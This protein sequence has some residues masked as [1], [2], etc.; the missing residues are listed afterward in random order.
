MRRVSMGEVLPPD[1]IPRATNRRARA[2]KRC[3]PG[4][5]IPTLETDRL[6]LRPFADDDL[7][8]LAGLHAEAT[9]W[10]FPLRRGM[11]EEETAAFLDRV[12]EQSDDPGRPAFH[13]VTERATGSLIGWAGLSVPDFLP[14]ILPAV[15][16]GWRLGIDHRGK[17][18]ATEAAAAALFWGFDELGLDEIVSVYEPE[19]LPSGRVMDRLGFGPGSAMTEPERGLPLL[20]R[21]LTSGDWRT[22]DR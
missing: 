10:W 13:A 20:V 5:V 8:A 17:G 14:D 18:Y 21:R 3:H 9:F 6:V 12:I 1:G 2:G 11:T 22:R 15:E 4:T 16:V 19:N 7:D